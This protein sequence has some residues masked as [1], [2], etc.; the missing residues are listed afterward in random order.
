[1]LYRPASGVIARSFHPLGANQQLKPV[2]PESIIK[3][4]KRSEPGSL[5]GRSTILAYGGFWT[6]VPKGAVLHAAPAYR[7]PEFDGLVN[8]HRL[9]EERISLPT[10]EALAAPILAQTNSQN[11]RHYVRITDRSENAYKHTLTIEDYF[12]KFVNRT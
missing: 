3:K 4:E 8:A 5:V 1:M 6:I 7:K 9:T 2:D 10:F 12:Y 11:C